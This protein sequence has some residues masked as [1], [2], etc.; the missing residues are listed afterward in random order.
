MTENEAIVTVEAPVRRRMFLGMAAGRPCVPAIKPGMHLYMSSQQPDGS[1]RLRRI[2]DGAPPDTSVSLD[3]ARFYHVGTGKYHFSPV[4]SMVVTD[5]QGHKWDCRLAG[6]LS[7]ADSRQFLTSFAVNIASQNAPLTPSLAES[8]LANHISPNVHDAV[9]EY[10]IADLKDRQALPASWWE[11]RLNEW[12]DAYGITVQVGTIAWSSA[13]AEAAE[14]EAARQRD[15][16]RVAAARRRELEAKKREMEVRSEYK[17]QKSKIESDL[18]LS[19]HERPHQLQLLEKRHRKELIEAEAQVEAARREAEKAAMEHE[20]VLARLRRDAETVK[21]VKD[22]NRLA[23]DRYQEIVKGYGELK[24]TLERIADLPENLLAQLGA[25]DAQRANAAAE[26]LV[27]PEFGISAY[28]LAGLGFQVDRQS[29]VE[30]LRNRAATDPN[31]VTIRKSELRCRNIGTAKVKGLPINTSLQFEFRTERNGYV[32]LLNIGTSGSVY[33]HVPNPYIS[34]EQAKVRKGHA[35]RVPGPELL[36]W[37]RLGQLG[38]D[39]VEIGP[40]GWEHIAV[41][42][43]DEPLIAVFI[44]ARADVESPFVKLT[45]RELSDL[46][47]TLANMPIATWAADILSFLVE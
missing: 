46:G 18:E 11:K 8:W 22:R 28:K 41:L 38:L 10:S 1:C 12:L 45:G 2:M 42:V 25:L 7:V 15:V 35:Y 23:E 5:K 47:D 32:T 27:S 33:I 24:S 13:Q 16:E 9:Q 36:P 40:P 44:M 14:A 26:R 31:G 6:K 21:Q 4:F 43:S 29:L 39:Y 19:E 30:G 37:E 17:K 34:L 3:G 20:V